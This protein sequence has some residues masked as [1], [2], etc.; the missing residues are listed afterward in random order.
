MLDPTPCW[1]RND[2]ITW[3]GSREQWDEQSRRFQRWGTEELGRRTPDVI[4]STAGNDRE[5][6]WLARFQRLTQS[7]G[8][9]VAEMR[10][11]RDTDLRGLLPSIHVP[12]LVL[13]RTHDQM[14]DV[15]S[16]RSAWTHRARRQ[17]R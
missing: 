17:R 9:A 10:K 12:T 13:H 7:P 1:V 8:A 2:E 15:R 11:D 16:T 5:Q 14:V 3:E 6:R 4:P